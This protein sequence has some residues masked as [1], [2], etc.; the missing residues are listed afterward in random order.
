MTDRSRG[1]LIVISGPSAVGKSTIAAKIVD[2]LGARLSVSATTRPKGNGEVDGENYYFLSREEF[3]R[4]LGQGEFLEHAEYLGN[5]YGTPAG[6][7]REAMD[8][9][10]DVVL[11]IEVQ[12]GMQVAEKCPDAVMVLVLPAD[13][14]ALIDRIR[15]RGRDSQD[16]IDERLA[17]AEAEIELAKQSGVYRHFVVNDVLDDAVDSVASIVESERRALGRASD[18]LEQN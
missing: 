8:A 12:G 16:V 9:G 10:R 13:R 7:V 17:N 14:Q 6:P 1:M 3:E 2:R 11:E 4:K 15:G 18:A 5:L